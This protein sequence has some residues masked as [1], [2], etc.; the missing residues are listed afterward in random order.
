MNLSSVHLQLVPI[1]P[2]RC[3]PVLFGAPS[4]LWCLECLVEASV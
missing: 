1:V 3:V 4:V 2:R